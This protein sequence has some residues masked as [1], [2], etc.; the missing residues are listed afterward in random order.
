MAGLHKQLEQPFNEEN[1]LVGIV[2]HELK[3][4]AQV[5]ANAAGAGAVFNHVVDVLRDLIQDVG[6]QQAQPDGQA[7]AHTNTLQT[8]QRCPNA[9]PSP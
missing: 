6:A 2:Q 7:V 1:D 4:V 8:A 5:A 3:D 9:G